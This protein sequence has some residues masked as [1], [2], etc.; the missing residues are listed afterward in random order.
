VASSDLEWTIVRPSGLFDADHVSDYLVADDH[1]RGAFTSRIDLADFMVRVL[2][3]D[4]WTG[5]KVA[6]ATRE[7][8][9]K[10]L[11]FFRSQALK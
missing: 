11:E 6:I 3:D 9:P 10:T 2:D 8:A 1:V 5:R 7:G 4:R